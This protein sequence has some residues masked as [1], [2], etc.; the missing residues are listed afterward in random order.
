MVKSHPALP[1]STLFGHEAMPQQGS[2]LL[3]MAHVA[4]KDHVDA[5]GP[6]GTMLMVENWA[7][8][9]LSLANHSTVQS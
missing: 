7:E 2:V 5:P 9:V 8:L 3:S 4:I 1:L 6:P